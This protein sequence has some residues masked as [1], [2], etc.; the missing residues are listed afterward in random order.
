MSL[1][2]NTKIPK[3]GNSGILVSLKI[4]SYV[5]PELYFFNK[6]FRVIILTN[7]PLINLTRRSPF[8]VFK[9]Y[10]LAHFEDNYKESIRK[11]WVKITE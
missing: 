9:R 4:P 3:L 2:I 10:S 11:S 8:W 1:L 6:K 5:T 7:A